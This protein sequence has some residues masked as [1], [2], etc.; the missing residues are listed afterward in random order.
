MASESG[1]AANLRC[2]DYIDDFGPRNQYRIVGQFAS[3]AV[4][5]GWSIQP[6]KGLCSKAQ[7][8][9]AQPGYP[10]LNEH[11]DRTLKGVLQNLNPRRSARRIRPRISSESPEFVLGTILCDGDLRSV[12]RSDA[13]H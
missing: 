9:P 13:A 12:L 3:A 1:L 11:L 5:W 6:R 2:S 8:W 4:R 10:V 7:G